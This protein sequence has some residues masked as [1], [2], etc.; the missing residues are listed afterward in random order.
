M[1]LRFY[2]LLTLPLIGLDQISKTM[3]SKA[4][5]LGE[6]LPLSDFLSITYVL[7][8]GAAFSF[9]STA[10]GWQVYFLSA[11]SIIVSIFIGL[12]MWQIQRKNGRILH[13][14]ALTMIL[15]GALGN[16]IDRLIFGSV[17]DFIDLH[18]QSFYWPVFNFA[19]IFISIGVG[20]LLLFE[21]RNK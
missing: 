8:F 10:G 18:Y 5:M 16:L 9:L 6:S 3:V 1:K 2:F 15:A 21:L 7:N 11:V 12:W 20:L 19:D 4:F 17:I 13:I 14:L